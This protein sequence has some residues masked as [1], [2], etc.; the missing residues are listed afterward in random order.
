MLGRG[1][2]YRAMAR[3]RRV[4]PLEVVPVLIAVAIIGFVAG[5]SSGGGGGSSAP[6][7]AKGPEVALSYPQGWRASTHAPSIPDLT[8]ADV[9]AIAPEGN[10]AIAGLLLGAL[11][12]GQLAPL[13]SAFLARLP[14]LPTPEIVNLLE[15]QAYKYGALKVAG[16]APALT[17]F[18]IPNPGRAPKVFACYATPAA[19]AAMA[20]CEASIATVKVV[21]EPQPYQLTPEP[22][23]AA[24]ISTA[25]GTLDRLRVQLKGKLHPDVTVARAKRLASSLAGGF[26]AASDTLEQLQPAPAAQP[27]QG[28][29]ADAVG[30]AHAGYVALGKAIGERDATGY[31]AA[32]KQVTRAEADVD[33]ALGSFVLLGYDVAPASGGSGS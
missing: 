33:S 32:Q 18:V 21:G 10:A 5:H 14:Q 24:K 15:T 25:I 4:L 7:T 19:A 20:A 22:K 9:T 23:Y 3:R 30:R 29:L 16:F 13:P 12:A 27:V 6:P 11:P 31:L 2:V 28:A 17:L 26:A 1:P 8:I